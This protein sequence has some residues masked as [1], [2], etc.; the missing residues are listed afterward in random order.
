VPH[1]LDLADP[2]LRALAKA[3]GG[4]GVPGSTLRVGGS[5]ADDTA[6]LGVDAATP[7]GASSILMDEAYWDELVA[8][9][10]DA[11]LA[12]AWDLNMRQRNAD[13]TT[14]WNG[15]IS[16]IL[17]RHVVA[18]RQ[19][20]SAFQLGNEPGHWAAET[21]NAPGAAAHGKDFVALK[22]Q[23]AAAF[24]DEKE[25][26]KIQGP[27]ACFGE[28]LNCS[29]VNCTNG[30]QKCASLEYLKELLVAADGAIDVV[31]VHSYGLWGQTNGVPF[32]GAALLLMLML[33]L[34]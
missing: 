21:Y 3:F 12:L 20:V 16:E 27:D 8:F 14:V 10:A 7:W 29:K 1:R 4:A 22:Q 15:T 2:G 25:R 33:M 23:L 5:A 11:G 28:F 34:C 13:D 17:L 32:T 18:K 6:A 31:T 26:P 30:G 19:R 24:P 9:A